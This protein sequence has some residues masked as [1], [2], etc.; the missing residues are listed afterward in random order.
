MTAVEWRQARGATGL[1]RTFTD[2]EVIESS[3]VHVA[4][5][6]TALASEADETVALAL[7]LTVRALRNGSV[8]LDVRSVEQQVGV[9]G[10]PWPD[11]DKWLG[12]VRASPLAGQPPVLRVDGDLLYFDRYWLEEQQVCRDVLTMIGA[13]PRQ[14]SRDIDRLFPAGFE[15]QIGRAHV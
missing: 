3:D 5:R 14:A 2:A 13:K 9:E 1:L 4:Q 6:L 10:L 7:A 8:C 11:V 15:E 12:A